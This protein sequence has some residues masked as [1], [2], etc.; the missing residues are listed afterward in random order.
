MVLW[1]LHWVFGGPGERRSTEADSQYQLDRGIS[2][3]E[4]LFTIPR[5]QRS[6]NHEIWGLPI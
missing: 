4:V 6:Y 5:R 2:D 3:L 1:C